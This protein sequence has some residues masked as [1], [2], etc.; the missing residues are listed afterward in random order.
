M[1]TNSDTNLVPFCK[2]QNGGYPPKWGYMDVSSG[3][4]TDL[5]F[6]YCSPFRGNYAIFGQYHYNG[7]NKNLVFG[8]IKKS[9]DNIIE[10]SIYNYLDFYPN[11]CTSF[12]GKI[13]TKTRLNNSISTEVFINI[14][15]NFSIVGN[16]II[17][18][19]EYTFAVVNEPFDVRIFN[20]NGKLIYDLPFSIDEFGKAS[21]I[22]QVSY[23]FNKAL[24]FEDGGFRLKFINTKMEKH[25]VDDGY[26]E[27]Y[28]ENYFDYDFNSKYKLIDKGKNLRQKESNKYEEF[29]LPSNDLIELSYVEV[30]EDLIKQRLLDSNNIFHPIF[31]RAKLY[32]HKSGLKYWETNFDKYRSVKKL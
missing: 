4:R 31:Y 27:T 15:D 8:I 7:R 18:I 32:Q 1:K 13:N 25:I 19:D 5:I 30:L 24:S 21:E 3:L 16:L 11:S 2:F 9:I 28:T 12:I 14:E 10:N 29:K 23:D 22:S 17:P 6:G 20:I 26:F